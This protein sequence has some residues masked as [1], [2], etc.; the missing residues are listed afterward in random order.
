LLPVTIVIVTH[1][2]QQAQRVSDQC[3]FF[4]AA[5][6]TPGAIVEAGTT[7]RIFESPQDERTAGLRERQVRLSR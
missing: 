1:N 3:A 4:L 2:M 5:H 6:G 7:T